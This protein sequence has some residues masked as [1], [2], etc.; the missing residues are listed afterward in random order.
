MSVKFAPS[1]LCMDLLRVGEQLQVMDRR[2]DFLHVDL[3]DLRFV[4][5]MGLSPAFV[6]AIRP[7]VRKPIDCHVMGLGLDWWI[8]ALAD[9]GADGITVHLEA[10]GGDASDILKD[11]QARG[12]SAGLALSP[13][14]EAD[15]AAALLPL[16]DKVTVM[17]VKPGFP[18][19][20]FLWDMLPKIARLNE[21]REKVRLSFQIEMDGS[22]ADDNFQA[23][24]EAGTDVF[25]VG[26]AAL[27][28][29]DPSLE[30]AFDRM[31][32]CFLGGPAP[33][34]GRV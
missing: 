27:F 15:Q 6:R 30:R 11:I 32:E 20:P 2:A 7:A 13:E 33:E 25:V 12:C 10:A 26:T 17:T 22:C 19:A 16:V 24:R 5:N 31:E 4:E 1:L 28:G 21:L 3:M 8:P 34:R 23:L 9:A 29:R 18:G 14:T